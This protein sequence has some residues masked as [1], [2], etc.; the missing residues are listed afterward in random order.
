MAGILPDGINLLL[1][2]IAT[3]CWLVNILKNVLMRSIMLFISIALLAACGGV[4]K[5]ADSTDVP[6]EYLIIGEGG[7]ITGEYTHFLLYRDGRLETWDEMEKVSVYKTNI[8]K[9]EATRIFEEW[10]GLAKE[11]FPPYS[12]GNMNYRI[13]Y[14]KNDSTETY[15]WSDS[16]PINDKWSTFYSDT[17]QVLNSA[18]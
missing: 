15:R 6:N 10:E 17:F 14:F 8:E 12:P 3:P 18:K 13:G 5:G 7:G 4:K 2:T 16:Q 9:R 1:K 11:G